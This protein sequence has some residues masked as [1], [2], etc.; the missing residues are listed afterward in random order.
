[1]EKKIIDFTK[2]EIITIN[3][4]TQAI[5]A[6]KVIGNTLYYGTNDIAMTD[7]AREIYEAGSVELSSEE[8]RHFRNI[9]LNSP[10][11]TGVLKSA[12]KK[13]LKVDE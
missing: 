4:E 9:L 3:R 6:S 8:I 5:D 13:V 7:K 1:M 10:N 12:L 2:I 11:I